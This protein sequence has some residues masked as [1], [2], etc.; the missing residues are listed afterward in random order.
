MKHS[1]TQNIRRFLFAVQIL[2]AFFAILMV[3][4]GLFVSRTVNGPKQDLTRSSEIRLDEKLRPSI[5]SPY[6]EDKHYKLLELMRGGDEVSNSLK[7]ALVASAE[8]MC[9]F[10]GI[11]AISS[12]MSIFLLSRKPS[13]PTSLLPPADPGK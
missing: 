5:G 13:V 12:L 3:I 9:I 11:F 1:S 7:K 2:T 8:V 10:G 6:T 4:A